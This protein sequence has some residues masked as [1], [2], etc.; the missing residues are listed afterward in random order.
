MLDI[1]KK[2]EE[3]RNA[4]CKPSAIPDGYEPREISGVYVFEHTEDADACLVDEMESILAD[5][6]AGE[7]LILSTGSTFENPYKIM[8]ERRQRLAKIL[9]NLMLINQDELLGIKQDDPR[10]YHRYMRKRLFSKFPE[11]DERNWIIPNPELGGE[12]AL[13]IFIRQLETVQKVRLAL[14]GIG[15]DADPERKLAASPHI[16][17]IEPGTPLDVLAKVVKLDRRTRHANGNGNARDYPTHAISH[18]PA[19]VLKAETIIMLAKGPK[20]KENINRV[21]LRNFNLK[22]AA[23][24]VQIAKKNDGGRRKD[25][26]ILM[27]HAAAESTFKTLWY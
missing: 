16:G 23:S 26:K 21:A 14:L 22:V 17:F 27:D 5:S 19:N 2:V 25:V 9:E 1:T 7:G 11:L 6:E 12:E 3:H 13:E 18:G 8:A 24:L 4:H 10:S 15:P 20:K